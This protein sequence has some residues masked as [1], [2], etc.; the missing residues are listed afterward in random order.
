MKKNLLAVIM[1]LL[2][3]L[4]GAQNVFSEYQDGKI[5][6]RVKDEVRINLPIT[7]NPND[8]PFGVLPFLKGISKN[9]QLTHLSRPFHAAKSSPALQRTFLLEFSDQ[10]SVMA[11]I[12]E[13]KQTGT[14]EYAERVPLCHSTLTPNDPSYGSEW[15]LNVINAASAWN[16]FSSGSTIKIA[17]VD[18]AV[19]RTHT[20]LSG[21]LW[22][23]PGETPNN[24]I[25]DD[26]NGYIDDLNGYDV[27]DND[28]NPNPPNSSWD[29]GTHCAGIASAKTNNSTGIASIGFS[30]KLI[31]VK[32]TTNSASSN[33]VTNGY[34]GVVYAVAAGAD[35]ISMSWGGT[36]NSTT[37][38]NIIT[39]ASNQGAV[40]VAAAGNSNTNTMF[41]PAA[42]TECIAVAATNSND[43]KASFSNYGTWVDISAPGNNIYSTLPGNAYGN[44][45]GTSMACP[46]VAGLCGLMLSLNP[47]LTPTDIRNCLTSSATNI[48]SMNSS[49]IGQLG[50]GRIDAS[51]A[52]SCIS[53]TLNWPPQANFTA[54]VTTITAGGQVTFTDQSVYNPTNWTWSF[55]GGTPSSFNGQNP[56]PIVYNTAGTYNVSLTV[57]NANGNDVQTNTGYIIVNAASG[58]TKINL[59][60]PAGWTPVNYYTGASVGQDGWINGLNTYGDKEKAMYFD[61]STSPYTQLVNVW[62]AFGLAYSS[63][64]AKIVP[65]KIYDGTSGSPG[66][67]IGSTV[68]ATMGQIM[69][70]VAG[71]YYTEYSFVNTPVTLPAS[72]K[73]FVSIDLTNLNWPTNHDTLSIVS[74]SA[75]QTTPSAIWE[76]QSNNTWY[77]Y[78]TAGSWNL[79]ASLYIH[80]FLTSANSVA[81]ITASPLTL[82]AGDQVSFDATGSTFEDTLLWYFPGTTPTISNNIQQDVIYNTAGNY[83]AILYIIGGGC[84]L[85]DSSFVN[86]TVNA[87]P[88]L[89]VT[90]NPSSNSVCSGTPVALSATGATTY[91]WSPSTFLSTT[92]GPS[93]T[94]TPTSSITYNLQGTGA[95]GCSTTTSI[96]INVD[97]PPV[98][99]I[100][101]SNTFV[102]VGAPVIFDGSNSSSATSFIWSFPGGTP[103]SS[104]AS[105]E[106]VTY[107]AAGNYTATL[108]VTNACGVDTIV[109]Q[110]VGVGCTGIDPVAVTEASAFYN[111]NAQ[112]LEVQLPK[113]DG[114]YSLVIFNSLGQEVKAM[115]SHSGSEFI[116]TSN[117]APGVYTLRISNGD[118]MRSIK[119]VKE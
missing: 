85:F 61:A 25:D 82:C 93:T 74:N 12:D 11:I 31:A 73:F 56:P 69:S 40:L 110:V 22:T 21:N 117:L 3:F 16:Y 42:Y 20:D 49:Y 41:Y 13:L 65:M 5:W 112:Q 30:C 80:P 86:I 90:M 101:E 98:G 70:D 38:Q 111:S 66:A 9:H 103:S 78:T 104:S 87:N 47:G 35:V 45:S 84:H 99:N 43:T 37:A 79:S 23:N 109:S 15:H 17:I 36:S 2:S 107:A 18:N 28:N 100:V 48:N 118:S 57:S 75:G 116:S 106:T 58:C 76:K 105:S 97:D 46:L 92:S 71:N 91:A 8:L 77:Q 50:A 62:V 81:T 67:Q 63:N 27:A 39:W 1:L 55:P 44:M 119:F 113:A 52:M 10:S 51:A 19:D 26:G 64:P 94:S 34:D 95:N 29:H 102:C 33:S 59:P 14:V 96:S 72:K 115:S 32:A 54:N 6:F 68:N 114:A 108:I 60:A 88:T 53:S 4:A 7:E 24:N 83:Q 89:A